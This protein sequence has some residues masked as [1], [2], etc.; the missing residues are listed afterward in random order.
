MSRSSSLDNNNFKDFF[1][2]RV[3]SEGAAV[4]AVGYLPG[5]YEFIGVRLD[6]GGPAWLGRPRDSL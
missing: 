1:L 4:G 5:S 3:T 2:Y 6:G